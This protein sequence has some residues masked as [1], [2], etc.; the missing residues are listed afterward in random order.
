MSAN[1]R[2]F[3]SHPSY[4]MMGFFRTSSS[5]RGPRLF[6]S[7][8][9]N[10]TFIH[11][12]I[13][14]AEVAHDLGRDWV[15][16]KEVVVDVALSASQFAELLTTMNVGDGVPCTITQIG[17]NS[18]PNP[19]SSTSEAAKVRSNFRKEVRTQM[20]GLESLQEEIAS[21]LSKPNVL[22]SDKE[23]ISAKMAK[24]INLFSS[25]A[26][27]MLDSF[28]ES[29]EKIVSSGKA[30][31]DAFLTHAVNKAGLEAIKNQAPTLTLQTLEGKK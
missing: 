8:T 2:V 28:E 26:P 19:P 18:I 5:G 3:E 14:Q 13:K 24:L 6:Q 25:T 22:K 21:I 27:F 20:E 30:E 16:G 1:D 11:L 7:H 15:T 10:S 17:K 12:V 4:G 23:K 31:F 29:T 9:D